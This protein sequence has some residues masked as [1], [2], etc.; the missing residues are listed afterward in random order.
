MFDICYFISKRIKVRQENNYVNI[1][2][3]TVY[4]WGSDVYGRLGHAT[5]CKHADKP[6]EIL[7]FK[8]TKLMMIESGA[9]H[10]I[11]LSKDGNVWSW[12]KSHVHQVTCSERL[13]ESSLVARL[14]TVESWPAP[15]LVRELVP[16]DTFKVVYLFLYY[17]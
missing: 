1:S 5:D 7:Y 3:Y 8:G 4:S 16:T 9:A 11:A 13:D 6:K 17:Q 15:L 2:D 10:T 12:G 14:R